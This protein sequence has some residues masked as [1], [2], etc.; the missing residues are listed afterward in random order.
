MAQQKRA[1]QLANAFQA[2]RYPRRKK[3]QRKKLRAARVEKRDR[4][5]LE[6]MEMGS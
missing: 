2:E 4:A 6:A 3:S 5:W 1:K